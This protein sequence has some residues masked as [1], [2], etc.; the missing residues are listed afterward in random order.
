MFTAGKPGHRALAAVGGSGQSPSRLFYVVAKIAGH[1]RLV[2]TGAEVRVLTVSRTEK[3]RLSR[4]TPPRAVNSTSIYIRTPGSKAD[5]SW[6]R[7]PGEHLPVYSRCRF[8]QPH[9]S[10]CLVSAKAHLSTNGIASFYVVWGVPPAPPSSTFDE[11]LPEFPEHTKT[12]S[13][14]LPVR[15]SVTHH[16]VTTGPPTSAGPRRLMG[17]RL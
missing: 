1:R 9:Y 17:E 2:D 3:R 10:C 5:V 11:L 7:N 15:H 13:L 6:Y 4:T 14:D 12:N 8:S 16:F